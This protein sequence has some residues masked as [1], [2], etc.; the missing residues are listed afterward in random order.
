MFLANSGIM[1]FD[2]SIT[3]NVVT[4]S[5]ASPFIC[6]SD[7]GNLISEIEVFANADLSIINKDSP[8]LTFSNDVQP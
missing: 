7:F 1:H 3:R 2:K 5:N 4:L 6:L 8:K